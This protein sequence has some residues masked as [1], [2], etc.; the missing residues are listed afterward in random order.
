MWNR[1]YILETFLTQPLKEKSPRCSLLMAIQFSLP[2]SWLTLQTKRESGDTWTSRLNKKLLTVLRRWITFRF[3]EDRFSFQKR[4]METLTQ[5]QTFWSKTCQKVWPRKIFR[6][7]SLHSGIS[8]LASW[9]L[10][11]AASLRC[12]DSSSMRNLR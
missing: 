11:T 9:K 7:C 4:R 5:R 6:K 12:M 8:Y 10:T 2:S 3:R 1:L